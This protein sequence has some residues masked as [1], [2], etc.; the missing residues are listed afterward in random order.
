[1]GSWGWGQISERMKL[2]LQGFTSKVARRAFLLFVACALIPVTVLALLSL[3]QVSTELRGENERR[4]RKA[5]KAVGLLLHKRLLTLEG[6]L[7]AAEPAGTAVEGLPAP[8]LR[9]VA[10]EN[11]ADAR[12]VFGGADALP[13]LTLDEEAIVRGGGTVLSSVVEPGLGVRHILTRQLNPAQPE[14]GGVLRGEINPAYLWAMEDEALLEPGTQ[15]S[16][17]TQTGRT[18]LIGLSNE[19]QLP[20]EAVNQAVS[21]PAGQLRWSRDGEDFLATYWVLF[22]RNRFHSDSWVVVLSRSTEEVFAPV[23][24][25][26]RTFLLV[27]LLSF[28]VVLLL[29]SRQI[30]QILKPLAR[31]TEANRRLEGGRLDTRVN[32]RSGDEF[33]ELAQS[34]NQMAT[35]LQSQFDALALRGELTAA[36]SRSS[37]EAALL[38]AS[39]QQVARHLRVCAAAWSVRA[40]VFELT[41]VKAE[42][43]LPVPTG[44]QVRRCEGLLA[45]VADEGRPVVSVL[46]PGSRAFSAE[47]LQVPGA[48]QFLGHPLQ[49]EGRVVGIF[50]VVST[51]I[52]STLEVAGLS[53]AA[54]EVSHGVE[55]ARV[56]ET[57][58]QAELQVRQLQK[59][60]AVG[61]LAGGV[62]HDFNNLLT[63]II[64][65]NQMVLHRSKADPRL[66][67]CAGVVQK[68]AQKAAELTRQLLTFSRKQVLDAKVLDL[69]RVVADLDSMLQRLIGESIELVVEPAPGPAL[70][71]MDR[72]QLE[73]VIV[74]LVVN[75]RDAMPQGGRLTLQ[76]ATVVLGPLDVATHAGLKPGP[77]VSLRVTDTGTGMDEA[78]QA[79]IFEPFFTT[80]EQGKGTGLGLATVYGIVMQ[81][82]GSIA[83]QSAPGQGTTFTFH[84]PQADGEV[85]AALPVQATAARGTETILLVEDEY[86]VRT[87]LERSLR[88]FGYTVLSAGRPSDALRLAEE[89]AGPLHLLVTDM[90]MPEMSGTA[91]SQRLLELR[92]G[93]RVLL[94]SG[95]T[96]YTEGAG[97]ALPAHRTFLQKPFATEA[98]ASAVRTLLDQPAPTP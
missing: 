83:V 32:V 54:V 80:K 85:E 4:Q 73:Q 61:R 27:S 24:D 47:G 8:F 46:E 57:L 94:M 2:D 77:H 52:L 25:F 66:Q 21:G 20:P 78:T 89:H 70:V 14:G 51:R 30:R 74:N 37:T 9:I 13:P 87:L 98:L 19:Q 97:A 50:A 11:G 86:D 33:E 15:L 56:A 79:R 72:A 82:R 63:V 58:Q 45:R 43:D 59:M 92:P 67:E 75:A 49:V 84:F 16:V 48:V 3:R 71:W 68:T 93:L 18:L 39:V 17:L 38:Q 31:L 5:S 60:E 76:T 44:T 41:A 81:S 29:S 7:S 91:L 10:Y 53:A 26:R 64:G 69:N 55:R 12:V 28:L 35:Q 96:E 42:P 90:V 1:M 40:D 34:F 22:L 23:R 62:A 6:T 36:T 95:Y 65:Y 88:E